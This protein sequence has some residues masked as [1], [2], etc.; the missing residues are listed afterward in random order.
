[1]RWLGIFDDKQIGLKNA[2]PAQILQKLLV[3]KWS[4]D[5]GDRDMIVMQHIFGY[6]LNGQEHLLK[7]SL[8][9]EGQDDVHTAMAITVGT[10]VAIATKL[11]LQGKIKLTGVHIPNLPEVYKPVMQELRQAGI[12]FVEEDFVLNK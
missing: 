10:P 6:Q 11:I 1:L 8:V 3:D 9:V 12:E 4:L 5:E 2:T 7:S